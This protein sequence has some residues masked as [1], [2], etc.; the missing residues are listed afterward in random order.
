[1][2]SLSGTD[3]IAFGIPGSCGRSVSRVKRTFHVAFQSGYTI[4]ISTHKYEH[5][6]FFTSSTILFY[7]LY[8]DF[9]IYVLIT[10]ASLKVR[11]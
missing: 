9:F 8:S 3:F 10:K 5:S 2:M 4:C 1:M 7:L 11:G 6:P